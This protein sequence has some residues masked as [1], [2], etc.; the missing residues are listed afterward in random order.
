MDIQCS[1]YFN[2]IKNEESFGSKKYGNSSCL[3]IGECHTP[4]PQCLI[5][6]VPHLF[7]T[8]LQGP[9]V[10]WTSV[11]EHIFGSVDTCNTGA[12]WRSNVCWQLST[13]KEPLKGRIDLEREKHYLSFLSK[14]LG[15][16]QPLH[17]D[18]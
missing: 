17:R 10:R 5:Y 6:S 13:E 18:H 1:I 14:P 4:S 7:P 16:R 3:R 12:S 15:D 2:R 8:S 9:S 11:I